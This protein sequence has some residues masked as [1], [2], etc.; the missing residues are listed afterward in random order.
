MIQNYPAL[1]ETIM[2]QCSSAK[3]MYQTHAYMLT[4]S[5]DKHSFILCNFIKLCSTLGLFNYACSVL[6]SHKQPDIYLYNTIIKSLLV[7][8]P[9]Q[10]ILIYDQAR[11]I[12]LNPDSYTFPF[13]LKA[14]VSEST[15]KKIHCQAVCN[16]WDSDDHVSAALIQM[17]SKCGC[18][19]DGRKVFD[20]ISLRGVASWNAMIAGYA[21]AGDPDSALYL[22]EQMPEGETGS[23]IT[24]TSVISGYA[25]ANRPSDA[26]RIFRRM[27][28]QGVQPDEIA[29]LAALS[30]IAQ[31]GA[32]QLGE[33]IHHY[34]KNNKLCFTIPLANALMDMY[35]KSGNVQKAIEI[36]DNM[37][38]RSV[39]TWT[40][41]IAG[42]AMHGLATEALEIFYRMEKNNRVSP[43]SV[44]FLAVISACSHAGLVKLGRYYFYAMYP[45]YG[46]KPNIEHYGCMIDLLGRA[47]YLEEAQKLV[48]VM[49][50]ES[51]SAIWGSLL[52]A[53]RIHGDIK[54]GEESL[55]HLL[56]MEPHN[57]GNYSH[58]S[59]I[60]SSLGKWKKAG[61]TRKMMRSIGVKKIAGGSCIEA[62]N[63]LNEFVAGDRSH[64]QSEIIYNLLHLVY[65]HFNSEAT[66]DYD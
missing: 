35:A 52:A 58:M 14:V 39:V 31:L 34:I 37:E 18:V 1:F 17:Y 8:S 11:L 60:Y 56:K 50:F 43:N 29:M 63:R 21:K 3:H 22:F 19:W 41:I 7:C 36:F 33:W 10:A 2:K 25:Q 62:N 55:Q 42:L 57:S 28:L 32:L 47:G 23:V 9:E 5:L 61:M 4:T 16:G 48:K 45:R 15:G 13:V 64:P 26:I 38:N 49:P 30:A 6:K 12:G 40:T 44:T 24:W 65:G 20:G 51:S 53:S 46:I 66:E 54:L 59:N 27:Q